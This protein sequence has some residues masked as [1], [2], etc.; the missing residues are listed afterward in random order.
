M[1]S[2]AVVAP[3]KSDAVDASRLFVGSCVALSGS[4]VMFAVLNDIMGALKEHFVLTNEQ[5]GWVAAGQMGFTIAIFALGPLC[6]ALGMKPLLWFAFLCQIGGAMMV[7]FAIGFWTL[8]SGVLINAIGSGTIEAVCNPLIATLFPDRKTQ[9]LNQFHVWFPGGIVLG[10]LAC[11]ALDQAGLNYWKLKVAL[12]VLPT[13]AYGVMLAGQKFPAT[14]RVQSGVSFGQMFGETFLRPLFLVLLVCMMLTASLELGPQRWIPSVLEAGHVPGILV[15]VWITGLMAVMRFFNAPVVRTLGGI[16]VLLV[17]SVLAGVGLAMLSFAGTVFQ[18]GVAATVFA[19]GVCYFWPTMLGTAAERVP[20]GGALALAVLGGTGSLFFSVVTT[21][22]MG[23]IADHYLH[24]ELTTPAIVDGKT[25]D[26]QA[27]TA[28]V[29]ERVDASYRAWSQSLGDTKRD[30]ASKK[31]IA[32]AL[33]LVDQALERWHQTGKL[34]EVVTANAL[35]GAIS[36]GPDSAAPAAG[37]QAEAAAAK[38]EAKAILDPAENHG[39]LISFRYVAPASIFLIIVFGII[40]LRDAAGRRS[41]RHAP[42]SP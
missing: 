14:E 12:V 35:R 22:L 6:D 19:I 20:R 24:Q 17:S 18:I 5:V 8:F 33:P 38:A 9:K 29:L 32:G 1:S 21:P 10:G 13:L 11:Y 31:D 41:G 15:L 25:I 27:Q 26:R 30:Q 23:R 3:V 28:A 39:G 37:A 36:G 34:P 4:A 2:V 16:G 7:I 42:A 40:Y